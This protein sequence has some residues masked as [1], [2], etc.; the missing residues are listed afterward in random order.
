MLEVLDLSESEIAQLLERVG[1]GHLACC[2]DGKPYVVPIHY[3]Y[4]EDKIYVYTTEGKKSEIISENPNVCLQVEEVIDERRWQ[5]VIVEGQAVRLTASD[6]REE[7][8]AAVTAVNPTLTPAV[9]IRWM[10]AW[11]R[12]NIEAVYRIDIEGTSGRRSLDRSGRSE[13]VPQNLR[14]EIRH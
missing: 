9:S 5:S 1:Y 7:A 3:G 13:I 12:E 10:D 11:V 4:A 14:T 8:I 2:R 6:A